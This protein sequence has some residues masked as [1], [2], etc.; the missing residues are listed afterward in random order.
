MSTDTY[1]SSIKQRFSTVIDEAVTEKRYEPVL[2]LVQGNSVAVTP[3]CWL[4]MPVIDGTTK[5]DTV[6]ASDEFLTYASTEKEQ[7]ERI[8][9]LCKMTGMRLIVT[10]RDFKNDLNRADNDKNFNM[11]QDDGTRWTTVEQTFWDKID[12]QS[13]AHQTYVVSHSTNQDPVVTFHGT[14]QRRALY[15]KQLAKFSFD[16]GC[17]S[18]NV[19]TQNTY[20][21]LFKKH[22]EHIIVINF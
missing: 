5:Y 7:T 9:A 14:V 3:N 15:F 10:V 6:I 18:Y 21:P 16:A 20:K 2:A 13:W 19:V 11:V 22:I 17:V 4:D 8:T 1:F 12:R